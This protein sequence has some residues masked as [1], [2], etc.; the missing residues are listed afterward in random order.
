MTLF[1]QRRIAAALLALFVGVVVFPPAL[2]HAQAHQNRKIVNKVMTIY[3]DLAR[4]LQ[5]RG[6]V[7]I[8]AAVAPDGSVKSTQV[9]GGSPLLASTAVDAVGRW[10]WTP[11]SQETKELIELTFH[12]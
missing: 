6:T 12:P 11:A 2:S 5:L 10:K 7:K 4:R 9:L 3:P 8:Q 1:M